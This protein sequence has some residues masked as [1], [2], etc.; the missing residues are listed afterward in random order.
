MR[1]VSMGIDHLHFGCSCWSIIAGALPTRRKPAAASVSSI[2]LHR[3][4]HG[5]RGGVQ[6]A[7]PADL[8]EGKRIWALFEVH[9]RIC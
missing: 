3:A 6:G 9:C 7:N 2:L 1:N 8:Q 5:G 4:L